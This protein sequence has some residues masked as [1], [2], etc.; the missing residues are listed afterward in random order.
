[1]ARSI[2]E[3][4]ELDAKHQLS[5]T[6][7]S[8]HLEAILANSRRPESEAP[9]DESVLFLMWALSKTPSA[10]RRQADHLTP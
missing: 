6:E 5:N 8:G 10:P 3:L 1:M 2:Q 9:F 7:L 4:C